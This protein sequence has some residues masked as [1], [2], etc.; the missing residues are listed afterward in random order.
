[1]LA[2]PGFQDTQCGFKS[3]RREAGKEIFAAQIMTG[4]SFDVEALFIALRRHCR[5]IDVPIEWYFD[6][7]SRVSPVHDTIRMVTDVLKIRLN[8]CRGLYD[9]PRAATRR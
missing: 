4:W 7:D 9:S 6:A 2:V 1:M 3:F 8:G 5:V